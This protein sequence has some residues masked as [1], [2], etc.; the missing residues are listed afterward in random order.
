MVDALE[1]WRDHSG[2]FPGLGML[3]RHCLCVPASGAS[4]GRGFLVAINGVEGL[5][6]ACTVC[7]YSGMNKGHLERHM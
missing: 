7:E 4:C 2:V 1:W 3:A 5:T 6:F